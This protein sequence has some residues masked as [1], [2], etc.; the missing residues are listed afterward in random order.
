MQNEISSI[1]LKEGFLGKVYASGESN[2]RTFYQG[3]QRSQ[4]R[5]YA[6]TSDGVKSFTI[7]SVDRNAIN[8]GLFDELELKRP[9]I[10]PLQNSIG[11]GQNRNT[12]YEN[13]ILVDR[14]SVKRG[15]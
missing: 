7:L 10:F 5:A 8:E 6:A 13:A 2:L 3:G 12:Y 1:V 4:Y 11:Q 14:V 9:K 15:N